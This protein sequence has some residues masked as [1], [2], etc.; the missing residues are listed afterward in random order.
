VAE[1]FKHTA[2]WPSSIKLINGQSSPV[3]GPAGMRKEE[4]GDGGGGG[5]RERERESIYL[6]VDMCHP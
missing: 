5:E 6:Y 4:G 2:G 3:Q 1:A